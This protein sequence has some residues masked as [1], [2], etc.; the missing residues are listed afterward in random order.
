MPD[1]PR[2]STQAISQTLDG[3]FYLLNNVR[4]VYTDVLQYSALGSA[5]SLVC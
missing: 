4:H 2:L 1:K 3:L 5:T